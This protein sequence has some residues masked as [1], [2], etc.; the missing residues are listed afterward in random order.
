LS[1]FFDI[2]NQ[3]HFQ[4]FLTQHI[5][6]PHRKVAIRHYRS[7]WDSRLHLQRFLLLQLFELLRD[8]QLHTLLFIIRP[9]YMTTSRL[10]HFLAKDAVFTRIAQFTCTARFTHTIRFTT[11]GCFTTL[12]VITAVCYLLSDLFQFTT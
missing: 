11:T 1:Q 7:L 8:Y 4:Q 12:F 10:T 6:F 2:I 3:V 5:V 9:L